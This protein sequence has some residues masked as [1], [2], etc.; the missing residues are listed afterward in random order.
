MA[1]KDQWDEAKTW[2]DERLLS[3]AYAGISVNVRKFRTKL[4]EANK[5]FLDPHV[6]DEPMLSEVDRTAAWV[7]EQVSVQ[8]AIRSGLASL[9]GALSIPPEVVL[10]IATLVRLA[11]KLAIVYG[12]DPKT[13]SGQMVMWR[14][15]AAG[16]ETEL[17]ESGP[18]GMR[19]RD[20]AKVVSVPSSE[21]VGAAV[22]RALVRKSAWMVLRRVT[23]FVPALALGSSTVGGRRKMQ[24]AGARMM[25][26]FRSLSESGPSKDVTIQEAVEVVAP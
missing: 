11:Q 15:L 12:F 24:A 20:L 5:P 26:V 13:D 22:T 3:N 25:P 7:V 17:P 10:T 4:R 9:G 19:L 2:A 18:L 23:R 1:I 14:A 6:P 16:L 21:Q 8:T